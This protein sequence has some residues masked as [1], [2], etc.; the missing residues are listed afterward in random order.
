MIREEIETHRD[1]NVPGLLRRRVDVWLPPEY[2]CDPDRRFQVLY[3]HDGQMVFDSTHARSGG[4]KVNQTIKNLAKQH[5][6]SPPI[7]VAIPSTLNRNYEYLPRKPLDYPGGMKTIEASKSGRLNPEKQQLST[8]LI[9]WMVET[10]KTEIDKLYRTL[11]EPE[12]TALMGSSLGGLLSLYMLCEYP[13]VYGK[14]ACLS[15]HWPVVGDG[16]IAYLEENLPEPGHHQLYFDYGSEGLDSGY[17]PWQAKVDALLREKG[18]REGVD[19]ESWSFPGED[20]S[21]EAWAGRVHIPLTF[22]F[23][24]TE[25]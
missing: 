24:T 14:A 18:W 8:V 6:I 1:L 11:P 9:E 15:T 7:V 12:N 23:G 21:A 16:M 17:A 13:N 10:V 22:L 20:H 3:M 5:K 19:F 4:W 2:R 25:Y